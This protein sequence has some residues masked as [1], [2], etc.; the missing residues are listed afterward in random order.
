MTEPDAA[1]GAD[2][3]RLRWLCRRGMKELDVLLERFLADEYAA[4]DAAQRRDLLRL[5]EV[6]DPVLWVWLLGRE[7]PEDSRLAAL[8]DRIRVHRRGG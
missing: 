2:E 5:L 1:A 6:E 7:A 8:I 4:M 3:A